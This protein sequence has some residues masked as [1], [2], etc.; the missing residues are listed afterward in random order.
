MHTQRTASP[1]TRGNKG[2]L[3]SLPPSPTSHEA[4]ATEAAQVQ[5]S[6]LRGL[7]DNADSD[8]EISFVD[9]Q[10]LRSRASLEVK[11][12]KSHASSITIV[13]ELA[14]QEPVGDVRKHMLHF[15]RSAG[16]IFDGWWL[17]MICCLLSIA[18]LAALIVFLGVYDNQP[19]PELPSGITVNTVVALLSTIARTAFTIPVAEGLSQCKWNWFKQKPR[20]LRDLD[21]FD[22]ASR[23][24]WGSLSLLF[25]TKGWYAKLPT[26]HIPR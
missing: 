6:L 9:E 3:V 18:C 16:Q 4:H 20:P 1:E 7:D 2:E 21:L 14:G 5:E 22:Q 12:C 26:Y 8:T 25:R 17:E 15:N 19:L 11:S 24:P 13:P 10:T 23:G